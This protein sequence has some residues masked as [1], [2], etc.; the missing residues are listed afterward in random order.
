MKLY[1]SPGACSLS[2]NIALREADLKFDM[3]KVDLKTKETTEGH[4]LDV[5]PNGY[6]PALKLNDNT[7]L[8]EANVI[9]RWIA[10]Q[11]PEKNLFPKPEEPNYYQAL[12]MLSFV[13]TEMHKG[14][15]SLFHAYRFN[16]EG[17][18]SIHSQLQSRLTYVNSIFEK[19]KFLLGDTLS[20]ADIYLFNI[21]RWAPA[22][23]VDLTSHTKILGFIETMR[24]LDSAREALR[25]ES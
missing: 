24:G 17:I 23:K 6:V 19:Q 9:L 1:Y 16:E 2:V 8:T 5:N 3:V 14:F 15:G 7:L 11:S 25:S 10:D 20:I 12:Q 18:K 4:Y 13:A 21:L 22:I